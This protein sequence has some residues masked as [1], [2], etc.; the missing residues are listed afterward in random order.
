MA[1]KPKSEEEST[2]EESQKRPTGCDQGV[3][4]FDEEDKGEEEI[5]DVRTIAIEFAVKC[6]KEIED[7]LPEL[8]EALQKEF[9]EGV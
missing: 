3:Q 7:K 8:R 6:A 9:K 2:N 1:D 5:N 4:G